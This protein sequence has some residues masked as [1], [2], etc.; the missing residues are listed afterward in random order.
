MEGGTRGSPLSCHRFVGG[1]DFL[2]RAKEH[3]LRARVAEAQALGGLPPSMR[4]TEMINLVVRRRSTVTAV[5]AALIEAGIAP[6]DTRPVD[7]HL[8]WLTRL[9]ERH[10]AA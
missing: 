5:N 10:P 9:P 3:S 4:L 7:N 8:T 2:A 6:L 1:E